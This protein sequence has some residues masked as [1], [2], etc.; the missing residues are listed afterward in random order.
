[1]FA[2]TFITYVAIAALA[3]VSMASAA[4][5]PPTIRTAPAVAQTMDGPDFLPVPKEMFP[6]C[7]HY[8]IDSCCNDPR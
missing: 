5:A 4:P 2:R 3:V 6:M 7:C 1:M 8:K